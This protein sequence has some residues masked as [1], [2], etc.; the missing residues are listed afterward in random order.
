[1]RKLDLMRPRGE[2][3]FPNRSVLKNIRPV[4]PLPPFRWR[5]GKGKQA[6]APKARR[7]AKSTAG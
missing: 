3:A 5:R 6:A 2:F 1:M 4:E 7:P